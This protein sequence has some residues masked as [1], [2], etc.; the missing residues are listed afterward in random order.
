MKTSKPFSR[1]AIKYLTI[2]IAALGVAASPSLLAQ[3]C[4]AQG[5]TMKGCAMGQDSASGHEGHATH[6]P[7]TDPTVPGKSVFV[8]PVQ[9]VFDGYILIQSGLAQDSIEGLSKT[10][11][12]MAKAIRGDSMKMLSPKV[13]EQ[14]E[15]LAQA[16]DLETARTAYKSLSESLINYVKSLKLP[17]GSYYEAYCPMAKASWLQTDKT[18]VN[19]YMGKGMIHCGVIKG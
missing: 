1:N 15:A 19:P 4:C 18:V 14:A 7:A 16:K 9:T 6:V 5:S 17:V 8:Q 12:A 10:A 3:G 13:A 11:T 2:A